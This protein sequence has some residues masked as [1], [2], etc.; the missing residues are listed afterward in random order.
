MYSPSKG[1]RFNTCRDAGAAVVSRAG[2]SGI[3]AKPLIS[4]EAWV[5]LSNK[6]G[7]MSCLFVCHAFNP[8]DAVSYNMPLNCF[9]IQI[10]SIVYI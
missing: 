3:V 7:Q 4:S 1:G 2:V 5:D 10:Y 9:S 8:W 6:Y